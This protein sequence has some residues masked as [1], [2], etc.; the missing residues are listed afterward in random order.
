MDQ[1]SSPARTWRLTALVGVF[2]IA[3]GTT[4]FYIDVASDFRFDSIE[5]HYDAF[6][7]FILVGV[8]IAFTGFIGWARWSSR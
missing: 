8:L 5:R 4:A 3:L 6:G 2:L 1:P 7:A